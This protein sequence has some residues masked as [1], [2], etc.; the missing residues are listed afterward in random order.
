MPPLFR[1][2]PLCQQGF[3]SAS[4]GIHVPQCYQKALKRWKLN[5]NGPMPVMPNISPT[6]HKGTKS[7]VGGVACGNGANGARTLNEHDPFANGSEHPE[8]NMNLHPC[9]R[10]GRKFLFDRIAYHESVCKGNVKRKVFD[11]SKQRAIEGQYSGGCFGTPSAKG[12]KKAAPGASS[13]APGVPRTRWREQHREFIEAMRAARQARQTSAAMWGEPCA[14]EPCPNNRQPRAPPAIARQQRGAQ[15]RQQRTANPMGITFS[16]T[17]ASSHSASSR[18]SH[19][20]TFGN[21]CEGFG[22]R[23]SGR[24]G[25]GGGGGQIRIAN[26]NTTSLGMLQAFG[27]A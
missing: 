5:P 2:C 16:G 21:R 24:V 10:C 18:P 17:Q 14:K 15:Q 1:I 26:D 11:S 27:R 8:G 7:S 12:R 3:G 22:S 13:P 23:V 19:G 4:L 6:P 25:G 9:S 20:N